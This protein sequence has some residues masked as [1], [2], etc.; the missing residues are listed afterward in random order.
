ME[1][2]RHDRRP[3]AHCGGVIAPDD[4]TCATCGRPYIPDATSTADAPPPADRTG[5]GDVAPP[6]PGG[7][8]PYESPPP[9]AVTDESRMWA[10]GAHLSALAGV[11]LGG[12]PA[13][14][15]PLVVWLLRRDEHDPF[16]AAHAR[17]ALNFNISVI[18]YAV[19]GV[20]VTIVTLGLALLI[21]VPA[22]IVVF[23]LYLVVTIRGAIA[24]SR[25][26]YY[27]YPLTIRLVR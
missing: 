24:A 5:R 27:D 9:P 2:M 1:D 8:V 15:G 26:E 6:R 4:T 22:A 25:G 16:A 11:L 19:V 14:L 10:M 3:C 7:A 23:V 13:F 17:E 20:L 12:L 18:I 21:V